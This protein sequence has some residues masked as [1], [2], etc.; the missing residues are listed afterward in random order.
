LVSGV[1]SGVSTLPLSV[2]RGG[3]PLAAGPGSQRPTLAGGRFVAGPENR[4]LVAVLERWCSLFSQNA[5]ET[6][7][8]SI[9]AAGRLVSPLV[10]VAPTGC[11]KTHLAEGIAQVA[12][13]RAMG[14][15]AND[16]RRDFA[17]AIDRGIAREW[18]QR[19]AKHQ[20]LI[21]D[22]IDHLSPT[23][24]FQHELISLFDEIVARGH[25]LIAT[26]ARPLA[27]LRGWNASLINRFSAGLTLEIAPL[28]P[29]TRAE[30]LRD[31]A[32]VQGWQ[33]ASDILALLA[34]HAPEKPRELITWICQLQQ[35]FAPRQQLTAT[36]VEEFVKRTKA[37]SAPDLQQIV[38]LVSRYYGI[39]QKVLVSASRQA[40]AV[41]ARGMVVYL[42]RQLTTASYE[43]IAQRLGGRDHT[44]ILHNYHRVCERLND[45]PALR[46]ASDEL[47]ALLR[48]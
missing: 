48:R 21:I 17:D 13:P 11:G 32:A 39:P 36:G 27:H 31:L 8:A 9:E 12:G 47:R 5:T 26:S 20:V 10:L 35:Q 40:S 43:Q 7:P 45:Q 18:R 33:I 2:S 24:N 22:D 14:T 23:T 37:R 3:A 34:H 44:T 1:L 42:A 38:R 4:L 15:T 19:W 16:L 6:T 41:A 30:V 25:K 29:A 28:G 46:Q